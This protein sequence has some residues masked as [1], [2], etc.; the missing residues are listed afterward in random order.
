MSLSTTLLASTYKE[1]SVL[2]VDHLPETEIAVAVS[3]AEFV[4]LLVETNSSHFGE[5][6]R[7]TRI[8]DRLLMV[9]L[10]QSDRPVLRARQICNIDFYCQ[11]GFN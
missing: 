3:D 1:W 5:S 11:I 7:R 6:A 4:A 8:R 2:C 10:P 9:P